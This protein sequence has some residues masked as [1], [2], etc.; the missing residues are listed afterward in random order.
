VSLRS[1]AFLDRDGTL[2]AAVLDPTSG[3]PESPLRVADVELL[4]G[5]AAGARELARAG[6]ALV[7]VTNQPA[8]AKGKASV[9]ELL[10]VHGRVVELLEREQVRLD[11]SR[12]C[13]HHPHGVLAALSGE[14][15]CRKPAPGMLLDLAGELGLE[16][17]SSWMLGDTDT[18]V[19]AGVAAGCKTALIEYPGSA[20]KRRGGAQPDLLAV[21]LADAAAQLLGKRTR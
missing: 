7:C 13:L 18:D 5:A 16:L 11:A 17:A 3:L 19:A 8:A 21:D 12:L 4:P 2:N 15:D 9:Q 1:A 10:A 20:H 6:Y 14:C